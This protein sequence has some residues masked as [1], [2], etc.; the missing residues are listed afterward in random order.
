MT[1]EQVTAVNSAM[2]TTT[3]AVLTDFISVLP[4][5]GIII[6]AA[7]VIGFITYWLKRLRKVR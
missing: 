7:F 2:S 6:G 5:I 1:S 4:T 3:Q